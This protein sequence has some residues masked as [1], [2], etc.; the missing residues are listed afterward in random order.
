MTIKNRFHFLRRVIEISGKLDLAVADFRD[1]GQCAFE[2]LFHL[3]A[4]G[5]KLHAD[6]FDL[7]LCC[8][9]Q[10]SAQQRSSAYSS[11]EISTVHHQISPRFINPT[12]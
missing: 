5:V 10:A 3:V 12:E 2:V 11:Q 8:P 9:A 4:H 7:A 1:L 6:F